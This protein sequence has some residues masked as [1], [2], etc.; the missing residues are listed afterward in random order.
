MDAMYFRVSSD[1]QTTENQFDELIAAARAGDPSRDWDRIRE[2]DA[3][4]RV[5]RQQASASQ[6]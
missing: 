6:P 4:G 2:D 1:R 3:D 5:R